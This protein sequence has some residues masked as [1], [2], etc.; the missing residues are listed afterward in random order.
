MQKLTNYIQGFWIKFHILKALKGLIR[1]RNYTSVCIGSLDALGWLVGWLRHVKVVIYVH[2]EEVSQE[3]YSKRA[4]ARRR[5]ALQS[6]DGIIAVSHFTADLIA[7]KYGV[8][9]EKIEVVT[10]GVDLSRFEEKPT[11][12]VRTQF[13]LGHGPLVLAVGRL[14]PRKGFDKLLEAWPRVLASVPEAQLAIGGTGPLGEQLA[15]EAR[16]PEM[17]ESVHMLGFVPDEVMPSLYASADLFAMPNRTMPDG[18]T[19]GFGLVFLEAAAAGTPSIAGNAGGAVDAVLDG[20]TGRLVDGED[21]SAIAYAITDLLTDEVTRK[22]MGEAARKHAL[23]QGWPDKAQQ[24]L[25]FLDRLEKA[26]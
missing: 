26:D 12:N 9:P 6:A 20:E 15:A 18:D 1:R 19:E 5:K 8:D 25:A 14:V 7:K 24:I 23:T 17:G 4:E 16:Q 11:E 22:R 13:G 10:N 3:A 2:G 21:V